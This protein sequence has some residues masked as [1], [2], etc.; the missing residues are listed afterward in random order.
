M[1]SFD[2]LNFATGKTVTWNNNQILVHRELGTGL[3]SSVFKGIYKERVVAIKTLS[4][5]YLRAE[6]IRQAFKQEYDYLLDLWKK[7][8][9]RYPEQPQVTPEYISGDMEAI[10]PF[11]M[12]ELIDGAPIDDNLVAGQSMEKESDAIALMRQFGQL[13]N[14]LHLDLKKT[15]AD[16]K[17]S[18][19]WMLNQRDTQGQ[20]LLKVTDWNVLGEVSP[21]AVTRDLFFASLYF[22]RLAAGIMP[23]YRS[24][25]V[26]MRLDNNETFQQLTA[27]SRAFL[28][29]ALHPNPLARFTTAQ[30]WTD[31]IQGLYNAWIIPAETIE[32]NAKNIANQADEI[33]GEALGLIEQARQAAN[34]PNG[35]ALFQK[36][37]ETFNLANQK[38][39]EAANL[40][41][42]SQQRGRGTTLLFRTL[43][44]R[45]KDGLQKTSYL[46][47]GRVALLGA[48]YKE[49]MQ[50]YDM[51]ARVS[52]FESE[53]LRRWYWLASAAFD[54]GVTE[55]EKIRQ[56]ALDGVDALIKSEFSLANDRL[57][58]ACEAIDETR[59]PLGLRALHDEVKIYLLARSA[60]EKTAQDRFPEAVADY[61]EAQSLARNLPK[62]PPTRWA[63]ELGDLSTLS[64]RAQHEY[65][66]TYRLIQSLESAD[67]FLE[68]ENWAAAGNALFA[69]AVA[70]PDDRRPGKAW[71]KAIDARLA[72][73]D[74][75]TAYDLAEQ[76]ISAPGVRDQVRLQWQIISGLRELEDIVQMPKASQYAEEKH[77]AVVDQGSQE[78]PVSLRANLASST[79]QITE[80]EAEK[81]ASSGVILQLFLDRAS[82]YQTRHAGNPN[83][84]GKSYT[85]IISNAVQRA[86]TEQELQYATRIMALIHALI[87]GNQ[88]NAQLETDLNRHIQEYRQQIL[89]DLKEH[90]TNRLT[91]AKLKQTFLH[92]KNAEDLARQAERYLDPSSG[93]LDPGWS[94]LL[95]ETHE[96]YQNA[97]RQTERIQLTNKERLAR[98]AHEE[99]MLEEKWQIYCSE[100]DRLPVDRHL[101]IRQAYEDVYIDLTGQIIALLVEWQQLNP[102]NQA[103]QEK[104]DYFRGA[105]GK[106]GIRGW[107]QF[108]ESATVSL[109]R[110]QQVAWQARLAYEE[111]DTEKANEIL[112]RLESD[113]YSSNDFKLLHSDIKT[114][115]DFLTW[116]GNWKSSKDAS[117]GLS[118]TESHNPQT[119][120]EELQPWLDKK[121]PVAY[122]QK[123]D[124][125]SFYRTQAKEVFETLKQ[126]PDRAEYAQQ[127]T[128]CLH[129]L[130]LAC[131]V[132]NGFGSSKPVNNRKFDDTF[133]LLFP[134]RLATFDELEAAVQNAPQELPPAASLERFLKEM[135]V[136][137]QARQ[138]AE[139]ASEAEKQA[140][141]AEQRAKQ[142]EEKERQAQEGASQAA[143]R[144]Q[145]AE[146]RAS[147]AESRL[148]LKTEGPKWFTWA[149]I[150]WS[151]LLTMIMAAI[152]LSSSI[153][154]LFAGSQ[155]E[156]APPPETALPT[157]VPTQTAPFTQAVTPNAPESPTPESTPIVAMP[158]SPTAAPLSAEELAAFQEKFSD[159]PANLLELY[160]MDSTNA[161]Y[162]PNAESWL[163]EE[164]PDKPGTM[165]YLKSS[166]F[167]ELENQIIQAKWTISLK[168]AGGYAVWFEDTHQFSGTDTVLLTYELVSATRGPLTPAFG[169]NQAAQISSAGYEAKNPF[170][171]V[172]IYNLEA[173]ETVD[174]VLKVDPTQ[175]KEG[176]I[177]VDR[178]VIA[179]LPML[180]GDGI[181]TIH[182]D[183]KERTV[184]FWA[185]DAMQAPEGRQP[186]DGWTA[187]QI[188]NEQLG[189]YWDGNAQQVPVASD[190]AA[191]ADA[192]FT[193]TFPY[194]QGPGKI[195]VA[196]LIPATLEI[197]VIY[198]VYLDNEDKPLT[199]RQI[200][201]PADSGMRGTL[202]E[203]FDSPHD[204]PPG[205]HTLRVVVRVYAEAEKKDGLLVVDA[206]MIL[207]P[208]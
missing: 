32:F 111:G 129:A 190:N 151:L 157:V 72:A 201:D 38:Y 192:E 160:V 59:L 124:L 187:H 102:A 108:V 36:A 154:S 87:N 69:A 74:L 4:E 82:D 75:K 39:S 53:S 148:R 135:D 141:H 166:Q 165:K 8:G 9:E 49:A 93:A 119:D 17:F 45:V 183:L 12:M 70:V 7:W 140:H 13:L 171:N 105:V 162:L 51:G 194:V 155:T 15:Y 34:Q 143:K 131:L 99:N 130:V 5:K 114:A 195:Q 153:T 178:V 149:A 95:Q 60:Q 186:V 120:R 66:T 110:M 62:Q 204:L 97:A 207:Q 29:K 56:Q 42:L 181:W 64:Q 132:E 139:R 199:Q 146:K 52:L 116:S 134:S 184:L 103:L 65:E 189:A 177:G 144:A 96:A 161:S 188:P 50:E 128:R 104:I 169:I 122:W 107:A 197:P 174:I 33:S 22:Y 10:P 112:A 208:K 168:D 182:P 86:L 94:T 26:Q 100:L 193:W 83:A 2:R 179:R 106:L 113:S 25:R 115:Q 28:L 16:I 61:Q 85:G 57:Q 40:L 196:V 79:V 67:K 170:V 185:D 3:T 152:L 127:A 147:E 101:K 11:F 98:I 156:T 125:H 41:E 47:R 163:D 37:A 142:A 126:L 23:P 20:P 109:D 176:I 76:A 24:G 158:L 54:L 90:L 89:N 31:A 92:V 46:E 14:V 150:G 180:D 84:L 118:Q 19:L 35:E 71:S 68:S 63:E 55:F 48:S 18:N 6:N 133:R 172:G 121:L 136:E 202:L 30:E 137:E 80:P 175:L 1:D 123:A 58:E 203:L 73:G 206:A 167:K 91:E 27:G 145:Q 205:L 159:F 78:E 21:E 43:S 117:H 200:N 198:E 44:E 138:A 81:Q 191:S 88:E 77:D 164:N 173:N